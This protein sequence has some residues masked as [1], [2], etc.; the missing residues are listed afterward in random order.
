VLCLLTS[1][2]DSLDA[3]P[4]SMSYFNECFENP[5]E[6]P[7]YLLG[8]NIDHGQDCYELQTWL[9]KHPDIKP[10]ISVYSAETLNAP[11]V[12]Y[13]EQDG[14]MI[15]SVNELYRRDKKYDW[16]T[17][18]NPVDSVGYSILVYRVEESNR[19]D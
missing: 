8:S 6:Y 11:K 12:P 7:K 13:E 2:A 19:K 14:W 1:A 15:I 5:R 10:F 9:E 18:Y 17:A 4:H 16:L 3:Y